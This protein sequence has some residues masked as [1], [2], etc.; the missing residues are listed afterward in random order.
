MKRKLPTAMNISRSSKEKTHE[1]L[2]IVKGFDLCLHEVTKA[3]PSVLPIHP[4]I[5]SFTTVRK[6]ILSHAE[7]LECKDIHFQLTQEFV[8]LLV[9]SKIN[10]DQIF[11]N[12]LLLLFNQYLNK[13]FM[14]DLNC[15]IYDK[16]HAAMSMEML[17]KILG[18][19][20]NQLNYR[21]FQI[22]KAFKT[23][24]SALQAKCEAL[25]HIHIE[26]SMFWRVE[27]A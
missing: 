9:Q 15:R 22:D 18:C 11:P 16:P 20:R 19:S 23:R 2:K 7:K 26:P 1:L 4:G 25:H 8:T 21:Q 12:R 3:M 14:Y 24:F 27:H 10:I 6:K 13:T 5:K 17:A